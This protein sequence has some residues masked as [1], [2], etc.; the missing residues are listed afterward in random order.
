MGRK[1]WGDRRRIAKAPEPPSRA[2][3]VLLAA[4]PRAWRRVPKG[5]RLGGPRGVGPQGSLGGPGEPVGGPDGDLP[6]LVP[7]ERRE[8]ADADGEPRLIEQGNPKGG[9]LRAQ[10]GV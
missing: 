10:G 4:L 3:L 7:E 2:S 6:K 5:V 1:G 8:G 9:S